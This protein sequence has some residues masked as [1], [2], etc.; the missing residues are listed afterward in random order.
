MSLTSPIEYYETLLNLK[1]NGNNWLETEINNKKPIEIQII[2]N[3]IMKRRNE[4]ETN[5]RLS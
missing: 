3:I 1:S 5:K 4:L 2:N